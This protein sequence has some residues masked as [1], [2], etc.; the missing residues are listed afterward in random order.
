MFQNGDWQRQG[1]KDKQGKWHGLCPVHD[2]GRQVSKISDT[3][4]VDSEETG[5]KL[6]NSDKVEGWNCKVQRGMSAHF[7]L[8]PIA[9]ES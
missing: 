1:R 3:K 6:Q 5:V 8:D 9:D 4:V 7:K 2:C